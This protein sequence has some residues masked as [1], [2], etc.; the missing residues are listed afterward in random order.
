MTTCQ[1]AANEFLRQFW[2]AQYPPQTDTLL[3]TQTNAQRTAKATRM[4]E[5]LS[6]TQ[7]KVDAIVNSGLFYSVDP[8]RIKTVSGQ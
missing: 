2:T 3:G 5:Y 6:R 4:V 1:T 7:E 8:A